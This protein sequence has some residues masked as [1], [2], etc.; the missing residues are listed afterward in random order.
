VNK[1]NVVLRLEWRYGFSRTACY[2]DGIR[3]N[4]NPMLQRFHVYHA[5]WPVVIGVLAL[6]AW[7]G[8]C[9]WCPAQ[10]T[11][12]GHCAATHSVTG[13]ASTVHV[14]RDSHLA[15]I[16]PQPIEPCSHCITHLPLGGGNSSASVIAPNNSS[17]GV[18]AA[19]LPVAGVWISTATSLVETHEH[20][21]P[22]KSSPR[23]LL[24]STFRI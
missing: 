15:P 8:V 22:G 6:A 17:H 13:S 7:S 14:T 3:V 19:D 4:V 24:N 21:P 18:V 23:Y 11:T 5:V 2:S 20:G 12:V 16:N 10:T 9:E 1:P